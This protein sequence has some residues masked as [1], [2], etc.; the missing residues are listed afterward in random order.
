MLLFSILF[1]HPFIFSNRFSLDGVVV[2]PGSIPGTLGV[3]CESGSLVHHAHMHTRTDCR[4][5][6]PHTVCLWE[7]LENSEQT[8]LDMKREGKKHKLCQH[9][10]LKSGWKPGRREA[11]KHHLLHS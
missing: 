2:D 10:N 3:G 11:E 6:N 1:I 7:E 4:V 8:H 5:A 9:S